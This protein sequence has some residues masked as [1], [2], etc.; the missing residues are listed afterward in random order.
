MIL[1]K[2]VLEGYEVP[3]IEYAFQKFTLSENTN[4]RT[5][6]TSDITFYGKARQILIDKVGNTNITESAEVKILW[7]EVLYVVGE[8]LGDS[9]S[10]N[11]KGKGQNCNVDECDRDWETPHSKVF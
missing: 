4:N 6:F 11:K 9:L 7:N 5:P 10:F 8:I 1:L 3:E 2:L